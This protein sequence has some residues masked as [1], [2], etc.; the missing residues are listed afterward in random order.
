VRLLTLRGSVEYI[1]GN[2]WRKGG[3]GP[4]AV[5]KIRG[6]SPRRKGKE[7]KLGGND[8]LPKRAQKGN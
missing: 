8:K 6:G 4:G 5:K 7:K 1:R 2:K 3:V